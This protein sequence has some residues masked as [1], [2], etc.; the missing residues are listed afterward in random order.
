MV[1]KEGGRLDL[2]DLGRPIVAVLAT[3]WHGVFPQAAGKIPCAFL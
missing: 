3:K 2:R 1:L